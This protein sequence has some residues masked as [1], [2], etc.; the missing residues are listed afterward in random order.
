MPT[1]LCNLRNNFKNADYIA[2]VKKKYEDREN[3]SYK[4]LILEINHKDYTMILPVDSSGYYEFVQ[5]GDTVSKLKGSDLI[6]VNK[7]KTFRIYFACGD[8]K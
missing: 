2:I 7:S 8:D 6:R 5:I 1:E 3:H 4:T